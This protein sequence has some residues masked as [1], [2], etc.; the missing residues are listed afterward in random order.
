L[1]DLNLLFMHRLDRSGVYAEPNCQ[2]GIISYHAITVVGYGT[3]NG[4]DYWVKRKTTKLRIPFILLEY[5]R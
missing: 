4:V 1:V 2:S 5:S 3:L